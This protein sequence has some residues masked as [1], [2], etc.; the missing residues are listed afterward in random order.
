MKNGLAKCLIVHCTMVCFLVTLAVTIFLFSTSARATP[1]NLTLFDSPDIMSGLIDVTYDAGSG[2]FVASGFALELDDDGLG[3]PLTIA[4]GDFTL[5]ATIDGSG[6]LLGGSLTYGGTVASL[7]FD[8]GALLTGNLTDFGFPDAGGDPLEFLFNVTGG[9]A[10]TL[11]GPVGGIILSGTNFGGSFANDFDNL[12]AGI[13]G[14]G[15]GTNNAGVPVP[16]PTTMLLVGVGLAGIFA[17]R[18]RFKT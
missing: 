3:D 15:F 10:A 9:D 2:A 17:F 13:P 5:Q 4:D 16:E 8:S 12:I 18:K 6:I 1:L 7:G 11:F 14:T